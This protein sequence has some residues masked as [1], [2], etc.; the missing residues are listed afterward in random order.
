MQKPKINRLFVLFSI[1]IVTVAL[2]GCSLFGGGGSGGGEKPEYNLTIWRLFDDYEVF[3]PIVKDYQRDHTDITFTVT[4]EKKDYEEYVESTVDSLAA[5]NGPDIWMIRNDWIPKQYEK[6]IPMPED[7]M[8]DINTYINSYPPVFSQDAIIDNKVYA[9][10]WSVDT[11]ALYYNTDIFLEKRHQMEEAGE[12]GRGDTTLEEPPGDWEEVIRYLKLLTQKDGNDIQGAGIALGGS[13]N[14]DRSVDILTALMLQ[15]HTNMISEDKKS[16]AFNL[17]ITKGTGEPYYPGIKALDFYKSFSDP[18]K[19]TYTWNNSM[20]NS[21]QAFIEGKTAMMI[22]Y[23]Y[24]QPYLYEKAPTLNYGVGPL[25]QI[26]DAKEPVDYSSYWVE[27]VTNNSEYPELAWDFIKYVA[28]SNTYNKATG[29]PS[30]YM[31]QP[32]QIPI[33][34][35]RMDNKSQ[36]FVFQLASA[37]NWYKGKYPQKVDTIFTQLIENITKYGQDSKTSID[38]AAANITALLQKE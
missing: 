18:S 15:N 21:I 32:D 19:E 12:I 4:Y 34:K 20:P 31:P 24:I 27:T 14:V 17:S 38:T 16:A 7:I 23:A 8:G 25:P 29:R 11:L 3:D 1:F 26:K 5:R 37:Q 35:Q 10:P 13:D 28:S 2:S 30:P 36:T 33:V 22:H 9:L 6:L